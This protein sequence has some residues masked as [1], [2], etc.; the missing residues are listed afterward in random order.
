MEWG[1]KVI[2]IPAIPD[3]REGVYPHHLVVWTRGKEL[4]EF[5]KLCSSQK[6]DMRGAKDVAAK[7]E[8]GLVQGTIP[9]NGMEPGGHVGQKSSERLSSAEEPENVGTMSQFQKAP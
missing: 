2:G 4:R 5:G 3:A 1:K 9:W 8:R 7:L 6:V